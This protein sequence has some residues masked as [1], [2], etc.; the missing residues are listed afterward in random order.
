MQL[1]KSAGKRKGVSIDFGVTSDW[2]KN[3]AT[4]SSQSQRN[5]INVT[6]YLST[7]TLERKTFQWKT[8]T[9]HLHLFCVYRKKKTVPPKKAVTLV[10]ITGMM[11][12]LETDWKELATVLELGEANIRKIRKENKTDREKSMLSSQ[13]GRT[14]KEKTQQWNVL[15]IPLRKQQKVALWKKCLVCKCED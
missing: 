1:M 13:C 15:Q 12:D 3:G 14:R 6:N 8:G 2:M 10:E 11:K 7:V 5:R 9:Q 4:F